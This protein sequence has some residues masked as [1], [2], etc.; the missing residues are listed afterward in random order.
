MDIEDS[1]LLLKSKLEQA[2]G[3]PGFA[4]AELSHKLESMERAFM[5]TPA[6]ACHAPGGHGF[7]DSRRID[8][9]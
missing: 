8:S 2:R 5:S 6:M 7:K 9:L 3:R 1:F 4:Q